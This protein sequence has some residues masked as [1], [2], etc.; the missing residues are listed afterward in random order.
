M[1]RKKNIKFQTKLNLNLFKIKKNLIVKT[2]LKKRIKVQVILTLKKKKKLNKFNLP[3]LSQLK[4]E[5]NA[6]KAKNVENL[7]KIWRNNF[8][9]TKRRLLKE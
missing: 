8:G 9:K 2:L 7:Q 6:E 3:I 5:R 1:S 4:K